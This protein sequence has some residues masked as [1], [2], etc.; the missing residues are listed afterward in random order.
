MDRR[1]QAWI[2]APAMPCWIVCNPRA[3][4]SASQPANARPAADKAE[5]VARI[6]LPSKVACVR[7]PAHRG[8]AFPD[9]AAFCVDVELGPANLIRHS[10]NWRTGFPSL[11]AGCISGA[12]PPCNQASV[13]RDRYFSAGA[14]SHVASGEAA[15][16]LDPCTSADNFAGSAGMCVVREFRHL[17]RRQCGAEARQTAA[18]G[19]RNFPPESI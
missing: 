17:R 4:R 8:H 9:L 2:S 15:I 6:V 13:A 12:S 3:K 18:P 5:R 10:C 19:G 11:N 16:R 14:Y 7:S 1:G